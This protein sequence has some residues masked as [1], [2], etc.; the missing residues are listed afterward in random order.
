MIKSWFDLWKNIFNYKEDLYKT[1]SISVKPESFKDIYW[2]NYMTKNPN[3]YLTQTYGST[4]SVSF[5]ELKNNPEKYSNKMISVEG[6]VSSFDAIADRV[7]ISMY[8][9]SQK[10]ASSNEE[11]DE[12]YLNKEYNEHNLIAISSLRVGDNIYNIGVG[13]PKDKVLITGVFKKDVSGDY[14]IFAKEIVIL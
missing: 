14:R 1:K 7:R 3:E 11:D 8:I 13:N 6:Y 10:V 5:S 12:K 4:I 2:N 9:S